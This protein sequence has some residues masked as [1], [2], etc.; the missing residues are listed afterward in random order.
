[1]KVKAI[2]FSTIEKWKV[3]QAGLPPRVV[4]CARKKGIRSFGALHKR[5]DEEL[6]SI[7][8]LGRSSVSVIRDFTQ[9]AHC[10]AAGE[11]AFDDV[12]D[13]FMEFLRPFE[14]EVLSDRYGL[15]RTEAEAYRNFYKLQEIANRRSLTRERVRQVEENA[16]EVLRSRMVS[17]SLQPFVDF[18]VDEIKRRGGIVAF[19][20]L[21]NLN[22]SEL[23]KVLNPCPLALLFCDLAPDRLHEDGACISVLDGEVLKNLRQELLDAL[24]RKTAPCNTQELAAEMHERL[25]FSRGVSVDAIRRMLETDPRVLTLANHTYLCSKESLAH[26]VARVMRRLSSPAHFREIARVTNQ[27]LMP[28]SRRGA[29]FYLRLLNSSPQFSK[30]NFGFYRLL[31]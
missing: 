25:P 26:V 22:P 18:V 19:S 16:L 15:Q 13:V 21:S 29:G 27:R 14:W 7:R 10:L 24:T 1:M 28:E 30:E 5:S 9:R 3:E 17:A 2:P 6:L 31:E 12:A 11:L 20:D 23:T 4:N 8:A